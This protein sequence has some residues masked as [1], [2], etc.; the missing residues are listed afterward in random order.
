[1]TEQ[2]FVEGSSRE[3]KVDTKYAGFVNAAAVKIYYHKPSGAKGFWNGA[4]SGTLAVYSMLAADST[5]E[6]GTWQF[7]VEATISGKPYISKITTANCV[8]N[9]K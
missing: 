4:V 7:Q 8:K 1:M 3:L 9:I 6:V 5:G 2:T